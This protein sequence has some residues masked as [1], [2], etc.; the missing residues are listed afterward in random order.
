MEIET[1]TGKIIIATLYQP[2]VRP[3]IPIPDFTQL[4]RRNIPVYML[5][6]LNANHP[7][8]GYTRSNAAGRQLYN[9]IL[10]R[11]L[12]HI[13]PHFP[14]YTAAHAN[15]TPDIVLTNYKTYHNT[16]I[17]AGP[18]TTSDHT[19]V[20]LT[21]SAAPIQIPSTP[22]PSYSQA[23]WDSFK[24]EIEDKISSSPFPTPA[25]LEEIDD[26]V[27]KWQE[28]ILSAT[29][30]HIPTT[31]HRTLPAP[32]H[33]HDTKLILVQYTNLR[34]HIQT[35]GFTRQQYQRYRQLQQNL[36]D[37]LTRDANTQWSNT[38]T[39]TSAQYSDP[40]T[41][42]RKIK[43]LSG[44][45]TPTTHYLLDSTN[46]RHYTPQQQE[47]LHREIWQE[48]FRDDVEDDGEDETITTVKEFLDA[49]RE[50]ITPHHTSDLSRLNGENPLTDRI[51][52]EEI[53][54]I[55]KRLR[56][57]CPG[58]SGIN[59]TILSHLPLCAIERLAEIY[60]STLSAGYFPDIWKESVL[61]L[62]PKPG[63]PS[64]QAINYR[65]IS[66]LEVPGK[67]LE[68]VINTRL[69]HYLEDSNQYHPS[70][71]GFRQD[72]GTTH[73]LALITECIAQ[74][75]GNRGQCHI[76]LRDITKAFDKV[77]HLGLKFKLLHLGLPDISEKI[78]C[79]F[80][81][82]RKA[83]VK[84]GTHLGENFTLSCGV[85]QGSV[86]SPTLFIIYTKDLPSP[87][88]GQNIVYA[89]DITQIIGYEGKSKTIM[90]L[91]TE[92]EIENVNNYEKQ[93]K[94]KTNVNK[95]T[96]IRLGATTGEPLLV[97]QDLVDFID[98]GKTLGLKVTRTGYA[99]H[100]KER[101]GKAIEALIKLFRFREMPP[102]IKTH[103]V[104][105]MVLPV[106]EYPPIPL[107]SLSKNQISKLQKIQNKA[108]RF[109]TNQRYP[110]TM[111]TAQIHHYTKTKPINIKLHERAVKIWETLENQENQT[112][113]ELRENHENM[114]RYNK[115]FPSS[116]EKLSQGRVP[117]PRYC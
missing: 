53:N 71:Y 68:R 34:T 78:L 83:R 69:R 57:T 21:I 97:S 40:N 12:Q 98:E 73:A 60:N 90:N 81:D 43:T 103:L 92:R 91:R 70:Q 24:T 86:L 5:A 100:V 74:N 63:K 16:H 11:T 117:R 115:W 82:D 112:Y 101:R 1:T 94:I 99:K 30:K 33:S 64:T 107:H 105:A 104:K 9:L 23:D 32:Q 102:K 48:V 10:N 18:L 58:Q 55:I 110:Y 54:F 37:S 77:W 87:I 44:Q 49:N 42:W 80:L 45:S 89:D 51:T 75:K 111:T 114:Q 72:R 28:T 17:T 35:H 38:I 22:R 61:R 56:K 109:A 66:L 65:P 46:T 31:T 47:E 14:T 26:E 113:F 62:I 88:I 2:P 67:I 6:D 3:Y 108:L 41:F 19:P 76:V 79:D 84:V 20:I 106:L 27:N 96:P 95:F 59:K 36:Q 25:T 85:P 93:W 15:T 7:S 50:R 116:F 52:T 8:L 4:F 13:G 39:Q 29:N